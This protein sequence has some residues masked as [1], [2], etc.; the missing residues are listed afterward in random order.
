LSTKWEDEG[1][2][3]L[4]ADRLAGLHSPTQ[5]GAGLLGGGQAGPVAASG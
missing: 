1:V 3:D 5:V 2:D 4:V